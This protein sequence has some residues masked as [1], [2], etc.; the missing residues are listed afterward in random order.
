[1][2]RYFV[3]HQ[4]VSLTCNTLT[5][6]MT[7]STPQHLWLLWTT[8]APYVR[9]RPYRN[10]QSERPHQNNLSLEIQGDVEQAEPGNTT[11]HTFTLVWPFNSAVIYFYSINMGTGKIKATRSPLF[12][13]EI[14]HTTLIAETWPIIE[15][16]TLDW[17]AT[18]PLPLPQP[19]YPGGQVQLH[20]PAH[21]GASI[22]LNVAKL[23]GTDPATL[24]N[25]YVRVTFQ[26]WYP[27][28]TPHELEGF[29]Q[30]IF[31][32]ALGDTTSRVA[33]FSV[34]HDPC[35][36]HPRNFVAPASPSTTVGM[37]VDYMQTQIFS[38]CGDLNDP[39]ISNPY[40]LE[41]RLSA[42]ESNLA[43]PPG[44]WTFSY[45]PIEIGTTAG[46]LTDI[47]GQWRHKRISPFLA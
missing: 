41:L 27:V 15:G 5:V 28:P 29:A 37:P 38:I 26:Q 14:G 16:H 9:P 20:G 32:N 33:Y 46:K 22:S 47:S 13:Y 45:G 2:S 10:Q 8:K 35:V 39:P 17:I 30:L 42:A 3:T 40:L 19:S 12:V 43:A 18:P 25:L 11:T 7:T 34:L 21:G 6:S 4:Q 44:L 23:I 31:A 24:C 36:W 1:M